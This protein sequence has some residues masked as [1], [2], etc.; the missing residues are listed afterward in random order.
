LSRRWR[1]AV[2]FNTRNAPRWLAELI[3]N[4]MI[5]KTARLIVV[6]MQIHEE[7]AEPQKRVDIRTP[8]A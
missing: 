7:A 6:G 2:G 5:P 4:G 3:E 8:A 1:S